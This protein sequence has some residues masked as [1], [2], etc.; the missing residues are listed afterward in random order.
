MVK[1]FFTDKSFNFIVLRVPPPWAEQTAQRAVCEGAALGK[2]ATG[3]KFT[4]GAAKAN[5]LSKH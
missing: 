5:G 4:T 1:S 2:A 3:V